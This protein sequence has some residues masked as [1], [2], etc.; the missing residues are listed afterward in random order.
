MAPVQ[1]NAILIPDRISARLKWFTIPPRIRTSPIREPE[2]ITTS[3]RNTGARNT[4]QNFN[5][6]LVFSLVGIDCSRFRRRAHGRGYIGFANIMSAANA[7]YTGPALNGSLSLDFS[8]RCWKSFA[9]HAKYHLNIHFECRDMV[10]NVLMKS[11][12]CAIRIFGRK[13]K[14]RNECSVARV[15][16]RLVF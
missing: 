6:A 12:P 11:E 16:R 1:R 10:F 15:L 4:L 14:W 2:I 5:R 7:V 13:S 3:Q 9:F 8:E